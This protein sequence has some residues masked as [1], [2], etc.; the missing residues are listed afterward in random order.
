MSDPMANA[1]L[2][3]KNTDLTSNPSSRALQKTL[4][5]KVSWFTDESPGIKPD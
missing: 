5:T 4:D 2:I 3:S 1:L